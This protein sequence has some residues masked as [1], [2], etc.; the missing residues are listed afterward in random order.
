MCVG[1][2][3]IMVRRNVHDQNE[4]CP[5]ANVQDSDNLSVHY[6]GWKSA[7]DGVDRIIKII[8]K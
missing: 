5:P 2:T 7:W 4:L 3:A 1:V 8:V 6:K